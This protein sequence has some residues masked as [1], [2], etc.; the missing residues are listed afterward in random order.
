MKPT[1]TEIQIIPV[2]P[3]DGLIGFASLVLNNWFYLGSIGIHTRPTGGFRLTY[4]KKGNY[5]LFYPI[6]K[7]IAQ[8]IENLISKKFEEV[9]NQENDRYN[10]SNA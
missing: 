2:R 7:Q 1:I 4:P 9:M 3:K 8:E 6:N 10:S 5:N